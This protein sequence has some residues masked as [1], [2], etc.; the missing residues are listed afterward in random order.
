MG[1]YGEDFRAQY[2][3]DGA[4]IAKTNKIGRKHAERIQSKENHSQTSKGNYDADCC[5]GFRGD[6][7]GRVS[8][9]SSQDSG[10]SIGNTG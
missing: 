8:A 10:N 1:R 5:R 4:A 7:S 6:E 3:V 9:F 2:R